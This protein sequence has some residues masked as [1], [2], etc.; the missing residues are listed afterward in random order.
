MKFKKLTLST[1]MTATLLLTACGSNDTESSKDKEEHVIHAESN[2]DTE[3]EEKPSFKDVSIKYWVERKDHNLHT[4]TEDNSKAKNA[5]FSEYYIMQLATDTQEI[6]M[7]YRAEGENINKDFDNIEKL[8]KE[9][10][11]AHLDNI[12]KL[13]KNGINDPKASWRQ[14]SE[15]MREGVVYMQAVFNDLDIVLND[16]DGKSYGFTYT[17]DGEHIKE[18][19]GFLKGNY[20]G[21]KTIPKVFDKKGNLLHKE[22]FTNSEER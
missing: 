6:R 22:K 7:Q 12:E 14:P 11:E 21:E 1:A 13:K 3:Q 15:R 4:I 9:I 17:G 10:K 5:G 18:L 16:K 8:S 19:E 2:K 20:D